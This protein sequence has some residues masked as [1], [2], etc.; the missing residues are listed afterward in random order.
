MK[1]SDIFEVLVQGRDYPTRAAARA[2]FEKATL[3]GGLTGGS[4]TLPGGR[5]VAV[6]I[7]EPTQ[8][9]W[10][11]HFL[12]RGLYVITRRADEYHAEAER[13]RAESVR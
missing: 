8:R 10:A 12:N 5:H 6:V 9:G 13:L 1:L 2:A 7:L 4:A 3:W 11:D